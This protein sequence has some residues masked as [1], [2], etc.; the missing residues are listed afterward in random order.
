MSYTFNKP[1]LC[2]FYSNTYTI[3][4]LQHNNTNLHWHM[5]IIE[6]Q[7]EHLTVPISKFRSTHQR[8]PDTVFQVCED[9][10]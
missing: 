3:N 7:E 4:K 1:L 2:K 9:F 5:K 6:L 10:K 8:K